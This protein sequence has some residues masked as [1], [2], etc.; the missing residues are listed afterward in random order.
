[1]RQVFRVESLPFLRPHDTVPMAFGAAENH[2][3]DVGNKKCLCIR[4]LLAG[5]K[6]IVKHGAA[7]LALLVG[8]VGRLLGAWHERAVGMKHAADAVFLRLEVRR[9]VVQGLSLIHI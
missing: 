7:C 5:C 4:L 9:L 3:A 1:M 6:G 8:R 2:L